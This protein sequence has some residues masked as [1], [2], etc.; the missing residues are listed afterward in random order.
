MIMHGNP[1]Y[2]RSDNGG[3]FIAKEL[4]KWLPDIDVKIAYITPGSL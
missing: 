3:E 2:I 1:E 4:R